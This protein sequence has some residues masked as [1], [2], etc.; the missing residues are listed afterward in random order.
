M[1][2]SYN[3]Y[4]SSSIGLI[5]TGVSQTSIQILRGHLGH[6]I[7][8]RLTIRNIF[9]FLRRLTIYKQTQPDQPH[10]FKISHQRQ[11]TLRIVGYH[12]SSQLTASL[13]LYPIYLK[14]LVHVLSQCGQCSCDFEVNQTK[15]KDGCQSER[16]V[17]T[18]DSK[19]DLPLVYV[20]RMQSSFFSPFLE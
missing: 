17:V 16:K 20:I 19:S 3:L 11:I 9:P 12:Y 4:V 1:H 5:H 6:L 15:I 8:C 13:N 10:F 2:T 7:L 18:H 14:L